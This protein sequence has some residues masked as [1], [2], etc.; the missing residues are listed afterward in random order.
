MLFAC[1][2]IG[3]HVIAERYDLYWI[4]RQMDI[5]V[6]ML[7]GIMSGLF[8]LTGLRYF[9]R[10][11]ALSLVICAALAIGI[12][13]ELLELAYKVQDVNPYYFFDATKDL[14]DDVIGSCIAYWMWRRFPDSKEKSL[15]IL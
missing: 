11:E 6:H 14:V 15:N 13:W 8:A 4:Y 9:R 5:P 10:K 1:I 7:G 12:G 2:T 3:V